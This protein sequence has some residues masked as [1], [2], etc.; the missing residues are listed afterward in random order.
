MQVERS[1]FPIRVCISFIQLDEISRS[2]SFT[3]VARPHVNR[4]LHVNYRVR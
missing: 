2:D 1:Y 3:Q 4:P